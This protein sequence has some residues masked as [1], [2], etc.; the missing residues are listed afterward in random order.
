M[1]EMAST[2]RFFYCFSKSVHE[3]RQDKDLGLK[4]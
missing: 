4:G 2:Q 3:T 1:E